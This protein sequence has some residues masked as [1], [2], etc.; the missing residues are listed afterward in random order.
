MIYAYSERFILV[1]S[2]DEV[3][4]MKGS[5]LAKMPGEQEEKFA[6]LRA[7]YGFMMAHPGKKL[8]FMGQEFGQT[9]EWNEKISLP[10]DEAE[11]PEHERLQQYV[12][13]INEFYRKHPAL[14]QQ[15]HVEE[16]FEWLSSMDADHSIITFMRYSKK[17][18][19]EKLLVVCNFTPVL[20]ENFKIGVPFAGKYKEIFNSDGEEFGGSGHG[21]RRQKNSKPVEWDGRQNS[22]SIEVPPLSVCVFRC[23]EQ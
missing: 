10:W 20:Y 22:I 16:G 2:H 4:H 21:N 5:M 9:T 23:T 12:S 1:L 18:Q 8:M 13:S 15:D 7:A 11:K 6:N 14:Y 19:G 17:A 3:V